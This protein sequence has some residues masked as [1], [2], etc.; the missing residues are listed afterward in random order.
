MKYSFKSLQAMAQRLLEAKKN[1][2]ETYMQF[3]LFVCFKSG[4]DSIFVERKIVE[5]A[6]GEISWHTH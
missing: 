6:K 5:Y 2:D 3:V 4:E 1:N